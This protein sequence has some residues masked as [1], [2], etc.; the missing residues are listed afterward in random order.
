[1]A[2][3]WTVKG[4][5]VVD[6]QLPELTE[7]FGPRNG[8]AGIKVK[9]SA[10][11]KVLGGWG[12]WNS[13]GQQTTDQ[14]GSFQVTEN[15]GGDRRQFKVEILLDSNRIRIKEGQRPRS[16]W[17]MTASRSTSS[18]TS[19]TRTGSRSTTTKTAPP[20]TAARRAASI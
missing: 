4:Q 1:M 3:N 18:S 12:W 7:A 16:G 2:E 20:P 8:L 11:S 6:H 9:V 5:I 17:T 19:P 13:W 10:R 15:D 14:D